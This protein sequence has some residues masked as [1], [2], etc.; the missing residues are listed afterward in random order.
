MEFRT[1]SLDNQG[2]NDESENSDAIEQLLNQAKKQLAKDPQKRVNLAK[3][4]YENYGI[5]P[6]ITALFVPNLENDL[7][8]AKGDTGNNAANSQNAQNQ[9][10]KTPNQNQVPKAQTETQE[11]KP[12]PEKV[13]ITTDDVIEVVES[14][15]DYLGEDAT[16]E[17]TKQFIKDNEDIVQN[18]ID[19]RL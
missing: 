8:E 14:F 4:L 9:T 13:S 5:D 19:M 15:Q 7:Q 16:L 10:G 18:E 6:S 2:D 1:R 17:E 12:M 11:V 3:N